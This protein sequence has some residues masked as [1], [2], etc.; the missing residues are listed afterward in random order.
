MSYSQ[1][2]YTLTLFQK[3]TSTITITTTTTKDKKQKRPDIFLYKLIM[4]DIFL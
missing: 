4:S 1:A 3:T 2:R